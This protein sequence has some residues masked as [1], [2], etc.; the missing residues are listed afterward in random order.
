MNNRTIKDINEDWRK[1]PLNG[2]GKKTWNKWFADYKEAHKD[3]YIP[4]H[5]GSVLTTGI[6]N[7][8][9]PDT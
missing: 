7:N 9:D 8:K 6:A 4:L 1:D 5:P 3:E 2:K